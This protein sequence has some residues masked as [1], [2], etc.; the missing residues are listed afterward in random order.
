MR[1]LWKIIGFLVVVAVVSVAWTQRDRL[2]RRIDRLWLTVEVDQLIQ[3]GDEAT[4]IEKLQE[5]RARYP[6]DKSLVLNLGWLFQRRG[7][8]EA[9]QQL[10]DQYLKAF[11]TEREVRLALG[12]SQLALLKARKTNGKISVPELN[13]LNALYWQGLKTSPGDPEMLTE[14]GKVFEVAANNPDE[15]RT[16]IKAWLDDW[17]AYYFR[18]AIRNDPTRTDS[19]FHLGV[20]SQRHGRSEEAAKQF[21]IVWLQS[22]KSI[23]ARFNL[24]LALVSV[25]LPEPGFAHM[26]GT[27][28]AL[29][30]QDRAQ[31]ARQLA[32]QMQNVKGEWAVGTG[33]EAGQKKGWASGPAIHLDPRC[34]E[35]NVQQAKQPAS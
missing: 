22:P 7:D 9:A 6:S 26:S 34:L 19:R 25:G 15:P 21:C 12:R 5:A 23:E 29:A 30:N 24:G 2:W 3:S 11:P 33:Q 4:A 31:E 35:L 20:V 10:Y 18:V 8:L 32:E 14:I 27:V 17:A 13:A 28:Q 16:Y 1:H